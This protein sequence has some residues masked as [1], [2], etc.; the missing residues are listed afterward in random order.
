MN[1]IVLSIFSNEPDPLILKNHS[2]YSKRHGYKFISENL[3]YAGNPNLQSI[4]KWGKVYDVMIDNPNVALLVLDSTAVIYNDYSLDQ[5]FL[6]SKSYISLDKSND[7]LANLGLIYFGFNSNCE[8]YV[9]EISR[10][11]RDANANS[12]T[13]GK[14]LKE[15]KDIYAFEAYIVAKNLLAKEQTSGL[16]DNL[17]PVLQL[18]WLQNGRFYNAFPFEF[19]NMFACTSGVHY[20]R[21]PENYLLKIPKDGRISKVILQDKKENYNFI[22]S[23]K[24][25]SIGKSEKVYPSQLHLNPDSDIAFVSLYTQNIELFSKIHEESFVAYCKDKNFGYH[26]YR[27]NPDFL[28]AGIGAN[29]AKPF[30]LR[31]LIKYHKWVIWVD[32]DILINN[33]HYKIHEKLI[34]R[35]QFFVFDHTNFLFNSGVFGVKNDP[36]NIKMIQEICDDVI[37]TKDKSSVYSSGGDQQIFTRWFYSRKRYGKENL[38]SSSIIEHCPMRASNESWLIHCPELPIVYRAAYMQHIHSERL[39]NKCVS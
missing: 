16:K 13:G 10:A 33:P 2:D 1:P 35:E 32:S 19:A 3:Y 31:E 9:L 24:E 4:F 15:S 23:I 26:L 29:W 17:T 18:D 5:I 21:T 14:D 6:D 25:K 38:L 36:K 30:L 28:P 27:G 12:L 20:M 11:L 22:K 7:E 8:K 34:D 39:S 37:N